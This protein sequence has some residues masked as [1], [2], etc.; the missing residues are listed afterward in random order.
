MHEVEILLFS[1][2]PNGL[3]PVSEETLFEFK[4]YLEKQG[5]S[6]ELK[7]VAVAAFKVLLLE[8]EKNRKLTQEKD[9]LLWQKRRLV[10]RVVRLEDSTQQIIASR[11]KRNDLLMG[12]IRWFQQLLPSKSI[13]KSKSQIK[14]RVSTSV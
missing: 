12:V 5:S 10:Q 1:Q 9:T 8:K 6:D 3:S 14:A 13:K 11:R 2:Q 4:C 7:G